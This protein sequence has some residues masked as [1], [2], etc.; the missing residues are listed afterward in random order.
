MLNMLIAVAG[1]F[2]VGQSLESLSDPTVGH[3]LQLITG[4]AM[5]AWA[6]PIIPN[7]EAE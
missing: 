4:L 1:G 3:V 2:L 5:Q 6:C 7:T